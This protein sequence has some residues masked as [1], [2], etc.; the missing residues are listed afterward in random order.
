[1]RGWFEF[2]SRRI[3]GRRSLV[4]ECDLHISPEV[5]RAITMDMT[6]EDDN[7]FHQVAMM[8]FAF[9][10]LQFNAAL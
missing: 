6:N 7:M 10:L 4:T 1:M 2:A 9:C 8:R 3:P 5:W